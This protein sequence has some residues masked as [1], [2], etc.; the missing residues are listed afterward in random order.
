MAR[1]SDDLK[2]ALLN[3]DLKEEVYMEQPPGFV[4]LGLEGK[5]CKPK[6]A[7]Y[8]LKQAPYAWYQ[9]IDAYFLRNGFRRSPSDANLYIYIEGGKS[10]IVILYVDDL[11]MMENH[12]ENIS[13]I[14]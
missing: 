2:S 13:P 4:I 1:V 6:K 11:V 12:E 3:E 8:G 9:Q 5:V 14:K 10:M 7:L